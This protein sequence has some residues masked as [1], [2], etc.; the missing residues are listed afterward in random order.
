MNAFEDRLAEIHRR[1]IEKLRIRRDRAR[2][3]ALC[4][5]LVLC[6]CVLA[7]AQ[8]QE[9]LPANT[10]E[11]TLPPD[12]LV[13]TV[14]CGAQTEQL[15]EEEAQWVLEFL[16]SEM[17]VT[18]V[19][20]SDD[21]SGA[22]AAADVTAAVDPIVYTITFSHPDGEEEIYTLRGNTLTKPNHTKQQLTDLQ[23][24]ALLSLLQIQ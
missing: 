10:Q 1:G 21:S 16:D 6:V 8:P 14:T 15:Q 11:S 18:T 12:T 23:R 9:A 13:L 19:F 2:A 3:I 17:T 20:T 24:N 22:K 4:L 5:P 7:V